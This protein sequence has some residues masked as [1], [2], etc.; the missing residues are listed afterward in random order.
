MEARDRKLALNIHELALS[1]YPDF[2]VKT[3]YGMP[4][5]YRDGKVILFFQDGH[6]FKTRYSTL[7]FQQNAQLDEGTF[8]PTSYA[9]LEID[10]KVSKEIVA[11]IKKA[12][13]H[14]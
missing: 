3:W 13:G 1:V 8:W 11:H 7:C 10:D 4:A 6:K 2:E 5:Y 12:L 14:A 9:I